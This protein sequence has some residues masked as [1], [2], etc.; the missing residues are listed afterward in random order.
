M[1]AWSVIAPLPNPQIAES[2]SEEP[3]E[4]EMA[5]MFETADFESLWNKKLQ[6]KPPVSTSSTAPAPP[7]PKVV[8]PEQLKLRGVFYVGPGDPAAATFSTGSDDL[9]TYYV[10]DSVL[11]AKILEIEE[12]QVKLFY[13]DSEFTLKLGGKE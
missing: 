10:G 2:K 13:R 6:G 8:L 4:F 5:P 11:D 12:T 7:Q 3:L 1:I 9:K